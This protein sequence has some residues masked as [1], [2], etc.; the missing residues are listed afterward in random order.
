MQRCDCHGLALAFI[1]NN[2]PIQFKKKEEKKRKKKGT[3][4]KQTS[5]TK[6][7][8]FKYNNLKS[9]HN[10]TDEKK[11]R[12]SLIYTNGL[13]T[14][15]PSK[16]LLCGCFLLTPAGN[17]TLTGGCLNPTVTTVWAS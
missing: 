6:L 4:L 16:E 3:S 15:M 8:I 14:L 1:H 13:Q 10:Q 5:T 2:L 9:D 17:K 7:T 12:H 11:N